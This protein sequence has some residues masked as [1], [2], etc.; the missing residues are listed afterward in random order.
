MDWFGK[1]LQDHPI[2]APAMGRGLELDD[3]EGPFSPNL[4]GNLW[5]MMIKS[6][7]YDWYKTKLSKLS[8]T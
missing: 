7:S 6:I 5:L 1:D 3:P 8:K 2:P 4:S